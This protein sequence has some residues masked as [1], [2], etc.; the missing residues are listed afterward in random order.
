MGHTGP[1]T[2][3]LYIF[4]LLEYNSV[5]FD[6]NVAECFEVYFVTLLDVLYEITSEKLAKRYCAFEIRRCPGFK[7]KVTLGDVL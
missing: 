5:V 3:S 4:F 2:G 1:V 7:R 6:R